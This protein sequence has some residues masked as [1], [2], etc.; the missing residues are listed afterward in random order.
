MTAPISALDAPLSP[1][2][3]PLLGSPP[4]QVSPAPVKPS[5]APLIWDAAAIVATL[6]VIAAFWATHDM[7]TSL[8]K[9][10]SFQIGAAVILTAALDITTRFGVPN[11]AVGALAAA[12]SLAA[13]LTNKGFGAN[14]ATVVVTS[15][16]LGLVMA[17]LVGA[18]R[19]PS[20]AVSFG[21][22]A[23]TT[24]LLQAKAGQG[25]ARLNDRSG[26]DSG[27]ALIALGA[28]AGLVV[29]AVSFSAR[30]KTTPHNAAVVFVVVLLSC[31]LA[32]A[33][34][35]AQVYRVGGVMPD[36]NSTHLFVALTAVFLGGTHPAGKRAG[37][38]GPV[39]VATSL[40]VI[41]FWLVLGGHNFYWFVGLL[42]GLMLFA[43]MLHGLVEFLSGQHNRTQTVNADMRTI[44][45][46]NPTYPPSPRMP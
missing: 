26:F 46:T 41:N 30:N 8:I 44:D 10:L 42:A 19:I 31:L 13:A 2:A 33:F 6:L 32:G 20:W 21:F 18:L 23:L 45:L 28:L 16:V 38:F 29:G 12:A 4:I 14:L 39:F 37:I 40:G 43:L 15:V 3:P 34:G 7:S 25:F 5:K 35:L 11:L 36:Q 9:I 17:T 1:P 24:A 22:I 27:P